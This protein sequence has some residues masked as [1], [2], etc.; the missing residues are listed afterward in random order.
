VSYL[1]I[2]DQENRLYGVSPDSSSVVVASLADRRV[3]AEMD[4]GDGPFWVA[5][6]GER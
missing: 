6:M 1:T 5:V 2:D 4:V 3:V